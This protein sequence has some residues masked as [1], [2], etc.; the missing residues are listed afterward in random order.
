MY[1]EQ[2]MLSKHEV[3]SF[4][5]LSRFIHFLLSERRLGH[6]YIFHLPTVDMSSS[7]FEHSEDGQTEAKVMVRKSCID[8][9]FLEQYQRFLVTSVERGTSNAMRPT[10][11]VAIA[12]GHRE[13]VTK[14]TSTSSSTSPVQALSAGKSTTALHSTRGR[15]SSISP[16]PVSLFHPLFCRQTPPSSCVRRGT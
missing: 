3:Q 5:G 1:P 6:K 4:A 8:L 15:P 10:Q 9:Y 14:K 7:G 11:P 16:I 12:T 13:P 2:F